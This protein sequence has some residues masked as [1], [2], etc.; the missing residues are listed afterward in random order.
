MGGRKQ[1]KR[2]EISSDLSA[3]VCDSDWI[4][5][6]QGMALFYAHFVFERPKIGVISPGKYPIFGERL[7]VSQTQATQTTRGF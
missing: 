6:I 7:L 1:D 5:P 2:D 4:P 3:V